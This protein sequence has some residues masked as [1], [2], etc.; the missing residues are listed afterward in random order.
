MDW[1]FGPNANVIRHHECYE[2]VIYLLGG[3]LR[4]I[5]G[6]DEI[7]ASSGDVVRIPPN[8]HHGIQNLSSSPVQ[9]MVLFTPGGIEELFR[10]HGSDGN[11]RLDPA[12][13]LEQASR[14]HRTHY[15]MPTPESEVPAAQ[16]DASADSA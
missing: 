12:K 11:R 16:Q 5:L 8:T 7:E 10:V 15:E 9:T 13:Y 6:E 14:A 2:E 1:T 4:F 3:R